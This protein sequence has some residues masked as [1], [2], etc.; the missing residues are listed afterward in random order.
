MKCQQSTIRKS[1]ESFM[2]ESS[3]ILQTVILL[4]V[5]K[6][7]RVKHTCSYTTGFE[8]PCPYENPL[9]FPVI[10]CVFPVIPWA[11]P[12]IP[13]TQP[14][15]TLQSPV[16]HCKHPL[17]STVSP[18]HHLYAR[19]TH[20][21]PLYVHVHAPGIPCTVFNCLLSTRHQGN[22]SLFSSENHQLQ[23]R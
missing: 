13:C 23:Y 8:N 14:L 1:R 19:V 3:R 16:S 11:P 12:V 7:H 6:V 18:C 22:D 21:K 15:Y 17:C 5:G 20:C 4:A 10:P 2:A 9:S